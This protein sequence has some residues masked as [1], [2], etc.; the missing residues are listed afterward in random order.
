MISKSYVIIDRLGARHGVVKAIS[1]ESA[2]NNF[3]GGY[4][5]LIGGIFAITFEQYELIN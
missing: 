1:K 3:T 5:G 4:I 2:Q